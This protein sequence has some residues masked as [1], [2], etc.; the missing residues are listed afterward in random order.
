[1]TI[2]KQRFAYNGLRWAFSIVF[3]TNTL[4]HASGLPYIPTRLY[5]TTIQDTPFVYVLDPPSPDTP[6]GRLRVFITSSSFPASSPVTRAPSTSLPFASPDTGSAFT[7]S[8]DPNGSLNVLV[9]D[10]SKGASGAS[11]WVFTPSLKDGNIQGAWSRQ[12]VNPNTISGAAA[13]I[14]VN[15]LAASISFTATST[16]NASIYTFAGMCPFENSTDEDWVSNAA[17]SNQLLILDHDQA[18]EYD[19][20]LG[21]GRGQP[22]SEAGFSITSL[23]P[24]FS[25]AGDGNKAISQNFLLLGGHTH[26]AFINM[27]QVALF[28]LPQA[29]WTFL[30]VTDQSQKS[31]LRSRQ[32]SQQV[33]PRSGHTSLLSSDGSKI[34]MF[35]GWV[36][37]VSTPA[38]PQLSMLNVGSGYGGDGDWEWTTAPVQPPWPGGVAGIYGHGATMLNGDIMMITGGWTISSEMGHKGKRDATP[39]VNTQNLLYNVT[40]GNWVQNYVPP[41]AQRSS[42]SGYHGGLLATKPQKVGLGVGLT[43]GILVIVIAALV[44]WLVS[45]RFRNK[46]RQR[47]EELREKEIEDLHKFDS[48][49]DPSDMTMYRDDGPYQRPTSIW[50]GRNSPGAYGRQ[51]PNIWPNDSV[52]AADR[53][54]LDLDIPSPQRGLRRSMAGRQMHSGRGVDE[55]RVS[56]G[57]GVIHP[58]A[59]TDEEEQ[60]TKAVTPSSQL[61]DP[62]KD[63]PSQNTA[64]KEVLKQEESHPEATTSP[65]QPKKST[66]EA[67]TE[68]TA[69]WVRKW[70]AST[71]SRHDPSGRV[72]PEKSDRTGS[73]LSDV[74]SI[75]GITARTHNSSSGSS[76]VSRASPSPEQALMRLGQQRR[77]RRIL[78]AS[79]NPFSTSS[80]SPTSPS[81]SRHSLT[82]TSQPPNT[83]DS[84][85]TAPTT[86]ATLQSQS[87]TLLGPAR[88]GQAGFKP[89]PPQPPAPE[90]KNSYDIS[91][92]DEEPTF[93]FGHRNDAHKAPTNKVESWV[94][95]VRRAVA[96][97]GRSAS[98]TNSAASTRAKAMAQV[99]PSG[100]LTVY[101]VSSSGSRGDDSPASSPTKKGGVTQD[102][103]AHRLGDKD[104][105][106]VRRSASEGATSFLMKRQGAKDWG[107]KDGTSSPDH[108]SGTDLGERERSQSLANAP[109]PAM[110]RLVDDSTPPTMTSQSNADDEWDVE[111][112]VESRNIQVMFSVPKERLRVVNADVDAVSVASSRRSV[113]GGAKPDDDDGVGKTEGEGGLVRARSRSKKAQ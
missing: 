46:L 79:L 103:F 94:G 87:D 84:F 108:S 109:R 99:G 57:S 19:F 7:S 52:R 75:S 37:D 64:G 40:S 74:S 56:R 110:G 18:S 97:A 92:P 17:Y 63:P 8:L 66:A 34:L 1:M 45:K 2:Q 21:S 25:E 60:Q 71:S 4:T 62:F 6:A 41:S 96:Q 93:L 82:P 91:V 28:S 59:E 69:H 113:S 78:P 76:S 51:A 70:A 22:I 30:P 13:Q 16:H 67:K 35:G 32:E 65:P 33:E 105:E 39:K 85:T 111:R 49:Y 104:N 95:S 77:P 48:H 81:R 11:L 61:E 23:Q 20:E 80:A 38:D 42:S 29:S 10:C 83:A 27:S 88:P 5:S 73:N 14:G 50:D 12:A 72:S 31:D 107:W 106:G 15:Y 101:D 89:K 9:G 26:D 100:G 55:R 54:G 44:G 47:E 68:E 36:G 90:R 112:A 58:I 24:S 102:A 53:T 98:L 86:F 3:L 43:L